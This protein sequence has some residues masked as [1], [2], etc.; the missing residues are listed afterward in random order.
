METVFITVIWWSYVRGTT[1]LEDVLEE[2]T[3]IQ[4]VS[5]TRFSRFT[6]LSDQNYDFVI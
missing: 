3:L 5:T 6:R 2:V 1:E 4:Q